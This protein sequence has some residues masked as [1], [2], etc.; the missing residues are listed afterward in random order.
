MNAIGTALVWCVVQV[1]LVGLVVSVLYVLVRR[2]RSAAAAPV[3]LSALVTVAILSLA[4]LSPWPRWIIPGGPDSSAIGVPQAQ[5]ASSSP[6]AAD[7]EENRR[8]RARTHAVPEVTVPEETGSVRASTH[9]TSVARS[10]D[11]PQHE[12]ETK[13]SVATVLWQALVDALSTPPA[14]SEAAWRWPAVAA[15][16][17]LAAMATGLAWLVLGVAAVR[18]QRERSR[19]LADR[20][21]SELVDVLCAELG[22]L[23]PIEVRQSD[24]LVTAATIGW[25]RPVVLLPV[26]WTAWT[27]GQLRAVLAHEIAHARSHD[28]LAL[29]FG[30]LALV[31]HFYHPLVHWLMN[32]L[33]LEQE[34]AADAAAASISGGQR[35][36]L[37]TIAEL[38]LRQADR[39]LLWPARTF[40]PTRTTFLRRIA[41]LRDSKLRTDRLSPAAR[42]VTVALVLFCGLLV[43]GLRGP[44]RQS[45]AAAAAAQPAAQPGNSE[46]IKTFDTTAAVITKDAVTVEQGAWRI[47]IKKDR[48]VELFEVTDPGVEECTLIYRAKLKSENLEGKAYLEMW[49]HMPSGG[50]YFSRGL[51]KPVKGTTNWASYETPFFLKKGERPDRVDLNVVT[52]G[53]GTLWIKDVE[54]VKGPLSP[55]APVAPSRKPE[56]KAPAG[57]DA[58][59]LAR[60]GWELWQRGQ[61][62]EAAAKFDQAVKLAPDNANAWNGLGWASFNSGD[63]PTAEKAFQ[64]VIQ[65]NP[66]HAGGLNGLGQLYLAQRKYDQAETYLVKASGQASAAWYGLARLYLLKGRFEDAEKWAQ[67]VVDSGQ[68]DEVAQRMLQAAKEKHLSDELRLTIEPPPAASEPG[69][70]AA[71]AQTTQSPAVRTWTDSTGAFQVD[72]EFLGVEDGKVKLKKT[73]GRVVAVPLDR[74]SKE[75]QDFVA[76]KT[77]A[78][79]KPAAAAGTV[80]ELVHDDGQMAGKSSI[81]GGGHAVRFQVDGDSWYVTSVSLHGSRYGYPQPPQEDFN[82]WICDEHFKPMATFHFPYG[83]FT[84]GEPEWKSFRVRPTRVPS[85]FIVSFG[86]NPQ[87]TKGVY[88]SYDAEGSGDSLVG[89]PEQGEPEPWTKGDWLIRCKV[90]NRPVK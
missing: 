72:A 90:E 12:P 7:A 4:A 44:A 17:L 51:A 18:W 25:R 23:R 28:F 47:E 20:E 2:L 68:G 42:F 38:A 86:F 6:F 30:Q 60:Q 33:R 53:R 80:Q 74:L 85:K 29:L 15:V 75:D 57:G 32:R 61:M 55:G 5:E 71:D 54:L 24:D 78:T 35:Q 9:P 81:A 64:R 14:G 88:V 58:S 36:Y 79:E 49:C 45:Q 69:A 26:D 66:V 76:A 89:V 67:K 19:P 84:R 73:D 52:Q 63:Q 59:L 16:F 46:T 40:L 56:A 48:T 70:K 3:V 65:L 1:T 37:A 27:P 13:P 87:Q 31:L 62:I 21:L 50:D 8:V 11:R 83:S 41:M 43:A 82:V 39:P 34:L 10:E 22:C 77:G